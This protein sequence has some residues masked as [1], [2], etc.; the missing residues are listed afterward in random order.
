M[1]D[2]KLARILFFV[3]CAGLPWLWAVHL[4][5]YLEK[6]RKRAAGEEDDDS[7]NDQDALLNEDE[8][9]ESEDDTPSEQI[10]LLEKKWIKREFIGLILVLF[11]WISWIVVFQILKD[12]LPSWLLVR[13]VDD[14]E[15]TGW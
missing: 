1:R 4:L 15:R 5:Y 3:G 6:Q 14:A 10:L 8:S 7:S 2:D 11:A 13:G 12:S 9:S